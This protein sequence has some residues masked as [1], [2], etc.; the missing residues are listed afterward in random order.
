MSIISPRSSLLKN[1]TSARSRTAAPRIA[2]V[3]R[4]NKYTLQGL[5]YYNRSLFHFT[6]RAF[7]KGLTTTKRQF[8]YIVPPD[9]DVANHVKQK[10]ACY[11]VSALPT[12]AASTRLRSYGFSHFPTWRIT[13]RIIWGSEITENHFRNALARSTVSNLDET[14]LSHRSVQRFG[15]TE[16]SPRRI[17]F[18]Y[19]T[20]YLPRS[21]CR[22]PVMGA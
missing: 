5:V 11:Q 18:R 21:R 2:T 13:S 10:E 19:S 4:Q 12:V 1:L 3:E 8:K 20:K 14:R 22:D 7:Y 9:S 16:S 15:T 6:P 17:P